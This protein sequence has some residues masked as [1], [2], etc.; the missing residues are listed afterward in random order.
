MTIDPIADMLTR[1]RNASLVRKAETL[2]P[3]SKIKFAIAKILEKEKYIKAVEIIEDNGKQLKIGLIYDNKKSVISSIKRVSKVGLRVYVGNKEIR[4][5]LN[6]Y[7]FAIIS[8]SK[9]LM[10]NREARKA[11]LGGEVICEIY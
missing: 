7:G 11:G 10:T 1:I 8:T 3:Y 9:G 5:V 2:V 4:P 6:G